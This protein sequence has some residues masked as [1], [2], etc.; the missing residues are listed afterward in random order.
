MRDG[1]LQIWDRGE[2]KQFVGISPQEKIRADLYLVG[3]LLINVIADHMR[4]F[5]TLLPEP[6][7]LLGQRIALRRCVPGIVEVTLNG[8]IIFNAPL[9]ALIN[10]GDIEVSHQVVT[11]RVSRPDRGAFLGPPFAGAAFDINFFRRRSAASSWRN[12][13]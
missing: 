6:G 4:Q 8:E 7:I 5:L 11:K 10:K 12:L 3:D 9:S 1:A 13:K 2:Q